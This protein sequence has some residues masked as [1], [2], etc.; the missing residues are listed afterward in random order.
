M[1]EAQE[2]RDRLFLLAKA[3]F[4]KRIA[5]FRERHQ[6]ALLKQAGKYVDQ[7]TGGRYDRIVIGEAGEKFFSPARPGQLAAKKDE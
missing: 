4:R 3:R 7:I 6:P 1:L 2:S 5:D